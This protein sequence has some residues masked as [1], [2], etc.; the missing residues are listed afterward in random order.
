MDRMI[1]KSKQ[2]AEWVEDWKINVLVFDVQSLGAK[3]FMTHPIPAAERYALLRDLEDSDG[4]GTKGVFVSQCMK[5]QW[6]GN[7]S[8]LREFRQKEGPALSH[9]IDCFVRLGSLNP[10]HDMGLIRCSQE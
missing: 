2:E 6:A 8:A 3:N 7:L 4:A 5:V 10:C 1:P 9:I